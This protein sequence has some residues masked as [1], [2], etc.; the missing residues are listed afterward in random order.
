MV[1]TCLVELIMAQVG[2]LPG[3]QFLASDKPLL[4]TRPCGSAGFA[5]DLLL[6]LTLS[7]GGGVV[8]CTILSHGRFCAADAFNE[9]D[10]VGAVLERGA[11]VS[12]RAE[13]TLQAGPHVWGAS[14][15]RFRFAHQCAVPLPAHPSTRV[16]SMRDRP[17][18]LTGSGV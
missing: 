16:A 18:T 6:Q 5:V 17:S 9:L 7:A 12:E 14:G 13:R 4:Q 10:V 8:Q 11:G 15:S 1:L 2:D 3:T